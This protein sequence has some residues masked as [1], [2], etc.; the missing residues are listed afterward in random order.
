MSRNRRILWGE[1]MFLPP[2]HFQP[3]D[4]FWESSLDFHHKALCSHAWGLTELEIHREGLVNGQVALKRCSGLLPEGQAFQI[5]EWDEG[6]PSR[7]IE[8]HFAPSAKSLDV[9]LGIGLKRS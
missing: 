4:N 2:H 7:N 3:T 9:H 1:G 6:P 5:P 8:G